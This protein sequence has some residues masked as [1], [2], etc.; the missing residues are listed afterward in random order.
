[1]GLVVA[2]VLAANV[3][4]AAP[5]P[6]FVAN[7]LVSGMPDVQSLP[8]FTGIGPFGLVF[9]AADHLLVSDAQNLGFYSFGPTGSTT[10]SPLTTG[11]A[12]TGLTFASDGDLFSAL[13]QAGNIDQ[14]DPATGSFIRQLNPPG[15]TFPCVTGMATDPVSGDVFFGQPNSGGICPGTP[16]F[17]RISNPTSPTPTFQNLNPVGANYVDFSF[18]PDGTLY[19]VQ[20]GPALGCVVRVDGAAGLS[21]TVTTLA[22][23]DTFQGEFIGVNTV[24]VSASRGGPTL[25]ASGPD[26]TV[27]K[28]DPSTSPPTLT[29]SVTLATR[30][31]KLLIGPDGC[32][33]A[34][35]STGVD[36][37]TNPDGS[38]SLV[39]SSVLPQLR[40]FPTP[41][42]N[43]VVG[44]P[45]VFLAVLTNTSSPRRTPITFTVT[46]ANPTRHTVTA[47]P[48][49]IALFIYRGT[50][51]GTD[52]VI[53]TTTL[54]TINLASTPTIV[55]W[56]A[57]QP[58][59]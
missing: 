41:E 56:R 53:A 58:T 29:P 8:P 26:G 47:G 57:R 55:N 20:Q 46:G 37:L 42:V 17:T 10:P 28:I 15:T 9:D 14:I 52:N 30:V 32:L 16:G 44:R 39:P 45:A 34:T 51:P 19:A 59:R 27:T 1:L 13:Y 18:A 6:G 54:G 50:R 48:L 2:T 40:L 38:C 33:Y 35:Q 49:G 25:F 31:D 11:T 24:A 7:P 36:K 12:Q 23:F 4:A 22:C 21:P 3:G 43:D 5:A